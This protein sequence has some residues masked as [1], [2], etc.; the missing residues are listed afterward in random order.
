VDDGRKDPE[1]S[2]KTRRRAGLGLLAGLLLG[3][4]GCVSGGIQ[5]AAYTVVRTDGDFQIRRYAPQIVA[6]T[7]VDGTLEDAGNQAFRPLFNYISGANQ[8]QGKIAMTA[9][10][11][12]QRAG[13]KIAMTAPV[14]QTALGNQWSVTFMMPTNSTLETLPEPTDA[15][16]R[17]RAIPARSMA[18]VRYSGTWSQPRYETNLARLQTWMQAQN[19]KAT[20]EPVWARYNPPFALWFLRRN[21]ILLQI[22]E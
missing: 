18:A 4:G 7:V 9:P 13:T 15:R 8:S 22:R 2:P 1:M 21:E 20:G 6:E 12:Q 5:E 16:V 17:L 14:G 11:A 19:L 10:V 3:T